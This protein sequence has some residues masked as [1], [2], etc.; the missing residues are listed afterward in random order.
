LENKYQG[1]EVPRKARAKE[2][3][4]RCQ[5][6]VMVLPVQSTRILGTRN[7][8]QEDVPVRLHL[9]D[10][11]IMSRCRHVTKDAEVISIHVLPQRIV[12]LDSHSR[13]VTNRYE[14]LDGI[15]EF[16]LEL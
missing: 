2:T 13:T 9:P 6:L 11:G 10:H 12:S 7:Q 14:D 4:Y 1:M 15:Q 5:L 3:M 8:N 16:H